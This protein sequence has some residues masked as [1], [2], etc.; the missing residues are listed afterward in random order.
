MQ[1]TQATL[2]LPCI[3]VRYTGKYDYAALVL[4]VGSAAAPVVKLG[5]SDTSLLDAVSNAA[6]IIT[7]NGTLTVKDVVGSIRNHYATTASHDVL[8]NEFDCEINNAIYT[9]V[10]GGS[11]NQ[12]AAAAGTLQLKS[13][14]QGALLIDDNLS[15][16]T[17]LRLPIC[18]VS[19]GSAVIKNITGHPGTSTTPT[20][21]RSIYDVD[22]NLKWTTDAIANATD[23]LLNPNRPTFVEPIVF[24]LEPIVVRDTCGDVSHN[25]ATTLAVTWGLA[26]AKNI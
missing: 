16:T 25:T 1:L 22:G 8:E 11:A 23:A 9:D 17:T 14:W 24:S 20:V 10:F 21:T 5:V 26:Q 15:G 12:Y 6:T 7:G 18:G 3:R 19:N 13:N 2:A 4:D